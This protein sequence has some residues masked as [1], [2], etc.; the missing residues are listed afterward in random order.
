MDGWFLEM[1]FFAS[2][3]EKGV[4]V[5]NKEEN[6]EQTWPKSAVINFDP[7]KM[8]SQ[9]F[10]TSPVWLKPLKWNQG[11]YDAIYVDIKK[12]LLKFIQITRG[13]EH[14]FKIEY[15]ATFLKN[16]LEIKDFK[17]EIKTL[18]IYFLVPKKN[19]RDFKFKY[20]KITGQG[21]LEDLTRKGWGWKKTHEHE[22]VQVRGIQGFEE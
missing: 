4:K 15:F 17:I 18:E 19:V 13:T 22:Q 10:K 12:N 14:S 5:Y 2:L 1:W 16:L 7:Y 8:N 9:I 3:D 11:G 20:S 21:L 6:L